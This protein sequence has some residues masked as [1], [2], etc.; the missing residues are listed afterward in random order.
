MCRKDLLVGLKALPVVILILGLVVSSVGL[1]ISPTFKA[2]PQMK[3]HA[4]TDPEL[5]AQIAAAEHGRFMGGIFGYT[6]LGLMFVGGGW[7]FVRAG[8]R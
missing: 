4:E 6:G 2:S 8:C 3:E 1:M 7:L 5:A